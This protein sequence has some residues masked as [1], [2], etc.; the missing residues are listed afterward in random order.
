MCEK[1][2]NFVVKSH[3]CP[4]TIKSVDVIVVED[5]ENFR[6]RFVIGNPVAFSSVTHKHSNYQDYEALS[7]NLK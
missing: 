3:N 7:L 1:K 4:T 6:R 5:E 2:K